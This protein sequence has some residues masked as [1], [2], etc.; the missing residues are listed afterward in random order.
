M[1]WFLYDPC[2]YYTDEEF[3]KMSCKV[4]W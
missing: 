1:V 3:S 4:S 2:T